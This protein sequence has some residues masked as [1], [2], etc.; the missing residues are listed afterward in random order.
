MSGGLL[1]LSGFAV[2]L[3]AAHLSR[4]I[5]A[6][7]G[8]MGMP[9]RMVGGRRF[10]D[11]EE[12]RILLGYLRTISQPDNNAAFVS[13]INVPSRKIG[14]ETV[15]DL[16]KLGE[17]KVFS[18]W[19]VAQ[20][21]LRGDLTLQKKLSKP[22]EQGLGKLV[23]MIKD[24][25]ERMRKMNPDR[26][27]LEL[28]EYIVTKLS[29]EEY[30]KKKHPEDDENRWENVEELL[31]QASELVNGVSPSAKC[32][33]DEEL[34]EIEGL[35][36]QQLQGSEEALSSFLASISLSADVQ[37]A[38]DGAEKQC[39]TMSTIHA[40]KGL[41]WPV[42]FIPAVYDGSIPHSRSEDM[43]EERRLLYVAMTRAQA[44][45]Y[46]STPL[47]DS[48]ENAGTAP[49]R[50]LPATLK[51]RFSEHGT[52]IVDRVISDVA[53]IL[54]RPRPSQECLVTG[55]LE[56]TSNGASIKDDVWPIDGTSRPTR[57]WSREGALPAQAASSSTTA[58]FTTAGQHLKALHAQSDQAV[59][60][61]WD[62]SISRDT[63]AHI[64]TAKVKKVKAAGPQQTSM[65][66]FLTA[67]ATVAGSSG[68][69]A[70]RN[71]C[72]TPHEDG[73]DEPLVPT[74][75]KPTSAI[76]IPQGLSCH[77]PTDLAMSTK[78]PRVV[79]RDS[80]SPKRNRY[81][82]LSSSPNG[83][84]RCPKNVGT[85]QEYASTSFERYKEAA[86]TGPR[87]SL[88]VSGNMSMTTSTYKTATTLHT[89]TMS[90]LRQGTADNRTYGVRRTIGNSG[91]DTRKH[92]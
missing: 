33:L 23:S 84:D 50:F 31:T 34:P 2:L 86:M 3:R 13:I 39:I 20:K 89:T 81:F 21:V 55:T 82:Y 25:K 14:E 77:K 40:A 60:L 85:G 8:K 30:L 1:D 4:L 66:A 37:S 87:T 29:F 42:V 24:A 52:E 27:P 70:S 61:G 69:L 43:D 45:L 17:E 28:L 57:S 74:L 90:I 53:E 10:F 5:E 64:A 59:V 56:L 36:R 80:P 65:S 7:L 51:R 62:G 16:L 67:Q 71:H 41:E 48:K 92:K 35:K 38:E 49:S 54:R 15:R 73:D 78:R 58:G 63:R 18:V 12:I 6:E 88:S 91:W 46:L 76:C 9:Y 32:T 19:A 11:R 72:G 83:D 44:L 22:A 26:A 75:P 79:L 47:R 68:H